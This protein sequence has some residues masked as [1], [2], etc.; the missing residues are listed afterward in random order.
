VRD[1]AERKRSA[2]RLLHRVSRPAAA[3]PNF[4]FE[5]H[6]VWATGWSRCLLELTQGDLPGSARAVARRTRERKAMARQKSEDRVVPQGRRKAVPTRDVEPPGGGKAVPVDER[7]GQLGLF[8]GTA[9][10]RAAQAVRADGAAGRDGSLSGARAAPKPRH[11][12]ETIPSATMEEV[13]KRLREAFENVAANRGAPGPDRQGIEQVREHLDETLSKL[14][15]NLLAG[16]YAPGDIRRVWIPKAS[17]GVRGLGIPNVIDRVVQEAVRLVLEP[18][19]EP[20]FHEASHGFR[21]GRSCHTAIARARGYVEDGYEWV[22]DIDLEKFFDKVNH[23]RLMARL[24]Q[25]VDNQCLLM[26]IGRMLK[27]R[28]VMPDGV[29]VSTE[30]GVPQGGPLSPLLSNIVLDELDQELAQRGHRFVRYADDCNI[31]VR[32]E[33]AGQRVM[34]SVASFIERRLRLLVNAAKSAVARP[35]ERHFVGFRLRREP[36]DGEVEVLLSKRSQERVDSKIRELTPRNWGSSLN[37]CIT[38]INAYLLGWIGFFAICTVAI[39]PTLQ[40]LDAHLRRRLRAIQLAHWK[41]KRTIARRL[42]KLGVKPHTAWRNVYGGRKSLWALS[43]SP[44]VDRGLRNA[45]FAERGL[46][47]LAERWGVLA[48]HIGAPA[49]LALPSG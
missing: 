25:R 28:V 23:Q 30:E 3:K 39:K 5:V 9:E 21:P 45:F 47:S 20:T 10:H 46:V 42:I 11:K 43:H 22:V 32:S 1:R 29:V 38:Q 34:A 13:T 48:Q 24:A 6:G 26:L 12:E 40:R 16:A 37:A 15:A 19:Y 41:T 17:G 36:L 35:E 44:A 14:S 31:Y 7:T 27:A 49:Q 4:R 33:R 2:F 18:I 8:L